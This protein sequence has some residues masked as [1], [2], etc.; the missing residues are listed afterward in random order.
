MYRPHA[1]IPCSLEELKC[2]AA[3]LTILQAPELEGEHQ[4]SKETKRHISDVV[5][6]EFDLEL[7]KHT[8]DLLL[9]RVLD[10]VQKAFD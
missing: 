4:I 2:L 10:N 3:L 8:L 6:N 1:Y 7:T 5:F 9:D